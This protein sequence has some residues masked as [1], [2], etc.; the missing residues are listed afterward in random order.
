MSSTKKLKNNSKNHAFKVRYP[1]KKELDNIFATIGI[2][3]N[4]D[5]F[6][7]LHEFITDMVMDVK[8]YEI[9]KKNKLTKKDGVRKINN[10]VKRI[11]NLIKAL[12]AEKGKLPEI[13]RHS[14]LED[15]GELFTVSA[16]LKA[17]NKKLHCTDH[18]ITDPKIIKAKKKLK[19]EDIE[20]IE[21]QYKYL[22]RDCGLLYTPQLLILALK[23][24]LAPMQEWLEE[25]SKNRGGN[26]AQSLR[27]FMIEKA[28]TGAK[29]FFEISKMPQRGRKFVD[30]C[31][32]SLVICGVPESGLDIA[33]N[34]ARSE[35]SK[36]QIIT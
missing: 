24:I 18:I 5:N 23:T 36:K 33:I 12:E 13:V 35:R 30:F 8:I 6:K 29:A 17:T 25:N 32:L 4:N 20:N 16:S 11:N 10:L 28:I 31:H 15:F 3:K 9:I 7:I 14:S 21:T 27:R 34:K 26:P 2:K 1:Q 19:I 22:R